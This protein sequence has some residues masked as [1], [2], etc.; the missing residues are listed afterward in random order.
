MVILECVQ[1]NTRMATQGSS[2][3]CLEA[4]GFSPSR[5]ILAEHKLGMHQLLNALHTLRWKGRWVALQRS[6]QGCTFNPS[7]QTALISS[8][9]GLIITTEAPAAAR[10]P[11]PYLVW[12]ASHVL[13]FTGAQLTAQIK[14]CCLL[15]L[16]MPIPN[17]PQ[18]Y[19]R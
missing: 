19:G 11:T 10:A 5:E 18:Q 2:P 7:T 1:G 14:K 8:K 4:E 17:F 16:I 12:A 3:G 9:A 6:H 15:P 13:L